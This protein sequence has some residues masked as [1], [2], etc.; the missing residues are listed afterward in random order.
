MPRSGGA[1]KLKLRFGNGMGLIDSDYR[2]EVKAILHYY[3]EPGAKCVTVYQYDR[4]GQFLVVPVLRPE[5][6]I[7]TELDDTLRGEG[8]FGSTG[9]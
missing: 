3:A 5:L 9:K 6:E 2:G 4:I 7:V 8:G 1:L